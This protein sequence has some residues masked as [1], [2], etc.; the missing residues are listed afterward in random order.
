[1]LQAT[2]W[3]SAR[4]SGGGGWFAPKPLTDETE[5]FGL[6]RVFVP[7][8]L[9]PERART[10][11]FDLTATRGPVQVN[12]TLFANHVANPVGMQRVSGDTTGAVNL[13]NVTGPLDTHG[14]EVFGVLNQEPFIATVYYSATRSRE[15]STEDG[16]VRELPLTPRQTA[17]VD[18]AVEDDESGAYAAVEVFYTGRQALED[19][20]YLKISRPYTTAGILLSRRFGQAVIFA[21]GENL[22]NVRMTKYEPLLRF[23]V[24]E[25]GRWTV[26]SWAPLEGRRVNMGVRWSW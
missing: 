14:G 2:P 4:A 24:G 11:S 20:P 25:G 13:I 22:A 12:G 3:L 1:L 6:S 10:M 18:F 15:V 9:A 5:S 17:G 7:K 23:N 26:D 16:R 19:N 21:N 8:P